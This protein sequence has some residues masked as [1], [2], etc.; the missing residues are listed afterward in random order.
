MVW[1]RGKGGGRDGKNHFCLQIS[2]NCKIHNFLTSK[3]SNV[4][5]YHTK[6]NEPRKETN[7]RTK[8]IKG[9]GTLNFFFQN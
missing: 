9:P 5:E 1:R 7:I 6:G 4:S 8:K 2:Y 3:Y